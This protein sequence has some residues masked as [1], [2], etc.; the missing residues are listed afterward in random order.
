MVDNLGPATIAM[1]ACASAHYWADGGSPRAA[2]SGS[3]IRV[4]CK[5]F[6]KGSKNDAVDAEAI[7]EAR[8]ASDDAFRAGQVEG[9]ARPTIASIVPA[10]G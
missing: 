1:E 8:H 6:V 4:L 2:K 5:P 10:S 3:S 7:F 9:S